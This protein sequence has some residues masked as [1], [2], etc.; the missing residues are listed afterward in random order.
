MYGSEGM[1]VMKVASYL[2]PRKWQQSD[3]TQQ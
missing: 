2:V 1:M 3:L